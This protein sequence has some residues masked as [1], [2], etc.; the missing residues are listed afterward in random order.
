MPWWGMKDSEQETS[1]AACE[2]HPTASVIHRGE[3]KR[4]ESPCRRT[5]PRPVAPL[6]AASRS[7]ASPP[8]GNDF[9]AAT[10]PIP[11]W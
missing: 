11:R 4:E 6:Q 2:W 3:A 10:R 7:L 1:G 5:D 8:Y 9:V